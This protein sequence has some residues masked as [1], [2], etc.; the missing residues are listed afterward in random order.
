MTELV[1]TV[2]S[3]RKSSRSNGGNGNCVE[4]GSG[5]GVVGVRDTKD[6]AGGVLV[7]ARRDWAA[8]VDELRR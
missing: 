5:D 6:R 4:V 7:F 1:R 3:W 2:G 8:F